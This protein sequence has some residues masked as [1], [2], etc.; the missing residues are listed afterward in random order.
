MKSVAW[1]VAAIGLTCAGYG[2]FFAGLQGDGYAI[3]GLVLVGV[4]RMMQASSD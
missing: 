3:F 1:L 4:A 2:A